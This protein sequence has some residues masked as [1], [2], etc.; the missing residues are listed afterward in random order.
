MEEKHLEEG[1]LDQNS[2]RKINNKKGNRKK[3]AA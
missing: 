2:Q 1:G 3:T